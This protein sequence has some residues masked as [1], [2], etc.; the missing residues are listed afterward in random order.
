LVKVAISADIIIGPL[1]LL[2][3]E[4]TFDICNDRQP[5]QCLEAFPYKAKALFSSS[6][7]YGFPKFV[8]VSRG[9]GYVVWDR[10][11]AGT[12]VCKII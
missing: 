11:I 2:Q 9:V 4:I 5:I 6:E 10:V 7:D 3:K 8:Y 1:I 12:G